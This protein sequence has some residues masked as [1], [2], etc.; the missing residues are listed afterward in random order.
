MVNNLSTAVHAYAYAAITFS[1]WDI[2]T[3]VYELVY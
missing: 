2:A 3:K 1:R